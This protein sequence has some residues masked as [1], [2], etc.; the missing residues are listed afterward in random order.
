[1][2][3]SPPEYLHAETRHARRGGTGHHLHHGVDYVLIDPESSVNTPIL[4]S[5][6]RVN[7]ASVHDVNHGGPR[8]EGRGATW[9]REVLEA[10]GAPEGLRLLLL[11]QPRF[12]GFWFNPVSFWFAVR[13]DIGGQ[14]E[15]IA[16]IA[17]VN[18]TFGER[19]SY[20]C[21]HEDFST[22]RPRDRFVAQKIF[23]VSPF[24]DVSGNYEF[25]FDINPRRISI[26]IVLKDGEEGLVATLTGA[27]TPLTNAALLTSAVRRPFGPL[28]TLAL[29]YW[30][31][32]RLRLK[33]IAYRKKPAQPPQQEVSR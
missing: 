16:V 21:G 28:R 7:L 10:A 33:G 13:S 18:N 23:H 2:T 11:T 20:F 6:N 5:R 1:M 17:E 4:F 9:V 15:L 30:H 19:H 24:Q 32:L 22:I 8:G 31:A 12:F 3:I 25:A 29:I 27:R 14:D 26:K